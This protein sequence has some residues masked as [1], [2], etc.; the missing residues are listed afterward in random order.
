MASAFPSPG[1]APLAQQFQQ[2]SLLLSPPSTSVSK[3]QI[4]VKAIRD[5]CPSLIPPPPSSS[6]R[7]S[8]STSSTSSSKDDGGIRSSSKLVNQ[9]DKDMEEEEG[10]VITKALAKV[11]TVV[12]NDTT[13]INLLADCVEAMMKKNS[14][15]TNKDDIS[16]SSFPAP[17][18]ITNIIGEVVD[19]VL[20]DEASLSLIAKQVV[21]GIINM[22]IYLCFHFFFVCSF[23]VFLCLL[24]SS[25][26]PPNIT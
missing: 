22:S 17:L 4:F 1:E 3:Q 5:A 8:K 7:T 23:A 14:R 12:N 15:I 21:E 25:H 20:L 26:S 6:T 16:S 2:Q 13:L 24:S 11:A 19:A 9:E 18:S 10:Q